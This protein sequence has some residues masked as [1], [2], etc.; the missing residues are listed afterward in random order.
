MGVNRNHSVTQDAASG[1]INFTVIGY[2]DISVRRKCSAAINQLAGICNLDAT[3]AAANG[4]F[5]THAGTLFCAYQADFVCIH[6]P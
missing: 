6:A 1:V 4:A 3:R 2:F 5:V